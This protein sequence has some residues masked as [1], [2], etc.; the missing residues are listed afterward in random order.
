MSIHC[1]R[2]RPLKVLMQIAVVQNADPRQSFVQHIVNE[3]PKV[4]TCKT[5]C[6]NNESPG[7]PLF[8]MEHFLCALFGVELVCSISGT[9]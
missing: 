8:Y 3:Q 5:Y 2:Q 4:F 1:P 9:V 7:I 6:E